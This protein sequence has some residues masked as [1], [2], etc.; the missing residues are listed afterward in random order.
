MKKL[1]HISLIHSNAINAK[2]LA[3]MGVYTTDIL[4]VVN[5]E[6]EN[7]IIPPSTAI[8][9]TDVPRSCP[10]WKKEKEILT[11]KH[12]KNIP[13]PEARKIVEGYI[14]NKTYSQISQNN[15]K[16]ESKKEEN[17]QE[18]ISKLLILGPKDWPEFIQEIKPTLL[19]LSSNST[20]RKPITKHKPEKTSKY[21][22]T[23]PP[24]Q[25]PKEEIRTISPHKNPNKNQPNSK[26]PS[27][28]F[29]SSYP[30]TQNRTTSLTETE[31]NQ[32]K[33]KTIT[34]PL[35]KNYLI[36]NANQKEPLNQK[37]SQSSHR[38]TSKNRTKSKIKS[39]PGKMKQS[40]NYKNITESNPPPLDRMETEDA[41]PINDN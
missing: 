22:E 3:I 12:T 32:M 28:E 25:P 10:A 21:I 5:L 23:N 14:K 40:E 16:T 36:E 18:L 11:I 6:S 13:Y 35:N 27:K 30:N 1:K 34:K 26:N 29:T 7:Q 20:N 2:N 15:P 31:Q 41:I 38:S 19:K 9:T 17:Y 39:S 37:R 24:K 8:S 4:Y 33:N